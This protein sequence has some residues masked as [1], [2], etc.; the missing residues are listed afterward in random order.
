MEEEN[1]LE[2][3]KYHK[4]EHLRLIQLVEGA[5]K[6]DPRLVRI[7]KAAAD[8]KEAAASAKRAQKMGEKA[9]M[10]EA[11][12]KV[13]REKQ[14]ALDEIERKDQEARELVK[15]EGRL[16]AAECKALIGLCE[17]KIVGSRTYDKWWVNGSCKRDFRKAIY[18]QMLVKR[19]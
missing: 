3:K 18:V 16:L 13:A 5:Q 8:A 19:L 14:A 11:K 6:L 7:A 10:Q 9:L 2:R 17:E 4:A 12:D 15:A 1:K